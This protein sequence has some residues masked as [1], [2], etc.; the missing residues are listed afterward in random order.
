MYMKIHRAPDGTILVAAC[1]REL[2]NTMLMHGDLEVR[3]SEGFYGNREANEEEL[4]AA[5]ADAD[6]INL[7]GR[8][9]VSL[10]TRMGLVSENGCMIIGNVPHAQVYRIG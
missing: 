5:L 7:M 1:D 9:V 2:L 8:K 10:A 4:K 6:T 3:I